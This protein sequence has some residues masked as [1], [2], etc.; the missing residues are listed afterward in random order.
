MSSIHKTIQNRTN[1]VRDTILK[2]WNEHWW[3]FIKDS[4]DKDWDWYEISGNPSITMEMINNNPDKHWDWSAISEKSFLKDKEE[5]QVKI[6]RRHLAAI[7]I[8]NAYKNALVNP[9]C[10]LGL[11]RIERDMVFAGI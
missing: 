2:E 1:K 3:Q 9:N 4:P 10:Q 11:N 6:Y 8:Q 7:L 5:F